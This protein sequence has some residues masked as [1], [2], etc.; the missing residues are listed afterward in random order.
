LDF[1]FLK[2][3]KM[4]GRTEIIIIAIITKLKLD[5]TIGRLPKK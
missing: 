2:N 3:S 5:L 4:I 1:L